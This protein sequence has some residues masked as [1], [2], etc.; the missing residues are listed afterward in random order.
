MLFIV[1]WMTATAVEILM[2]VRRFC[3]KICGEMSLV[4]DS[5][6]VE[7]CYGL[8]GPLGSKLDGRAKR[9]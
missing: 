8:L 7:E 6:C 2:G 5:L 9:V 1:G 4:I 3:I